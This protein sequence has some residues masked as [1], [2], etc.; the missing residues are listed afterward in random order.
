MCIRDRSRACFHPAESVKLWQR[1]S[2]FEKQTRG[3]V[4]F[5]FLS[6]HPASDRRIENMKKWLEK[7]NSIYEQSDCGTFGSYYNNFQNSVFGSNPDAIFSFR[8]Y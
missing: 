1:M 6:T 2:R 5:E 7:A 8:G 3:Q 4:G